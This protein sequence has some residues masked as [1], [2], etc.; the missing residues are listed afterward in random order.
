MTT[1][2]RLAT[3]DADVGVARR[4]RR[5]GAETRYGRRALGA[6][7][8]VVL[9]GGVVDFSLEDLP[10]AVADRVRAATGQPQYLAIRRAGEWIVEALTDDRATVMRLDVREDGSIAERTDSFLLDTIE[11][12]DAAT[13]AI[14]TAGPAHHRITV[15]VSHTFAERLASAMRSNVSHRHRGRGDGHHSASRRPS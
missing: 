2:D 6:E 1:T 12:V 9:R 5:A 14:I 15:A 10:A 8:N 3:A 11:P 13:D 7:P 4:D